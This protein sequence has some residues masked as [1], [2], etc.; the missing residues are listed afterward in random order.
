MIGLPFYDSPL[1][2]NFAPTD[3]ATASSPLFNPS[4]PIPSSVLANM[5]I[6]DGVGYAPLPRDMKGKRNVVCADSSA[7]L[8]STDSSFH[9]AVGR[10]KLAQRKESGPKFRSERHRRGGAEALD[11]EVNPPALVPRHLIV[12]IAD[13]DSVRLWDRQV[14]RMARRCLNTTAKWRSSIP[15]SESK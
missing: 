6:I 12:C 10:G 2:S 7:N 1:L 14:S 3:Y 15:S 8:M 13:L 11:E 5:R 9:G 4:K